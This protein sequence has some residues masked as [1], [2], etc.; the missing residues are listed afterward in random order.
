MNLPVLG[1][2]TV[3]P[4]HAFSPVEENRN[5]RALKDHRADKNN[6]PFRVPKQ[7]QLWGEFSAGA[8]TWFASHAVLETWEGPRPTGETEL[9]HPFQC[10]SSDG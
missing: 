9:C 2:S 5:V 10:H 7:S 1:G 6:E 3:G 4:G 8:R